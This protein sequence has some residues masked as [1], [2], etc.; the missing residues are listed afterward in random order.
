MFPAH[1]PLQTVVESDGTVAVELRLHDTLGKEPLDL[2]GRDFARQQ[3]RRGQFAGRARRHKV[4]RPLQE[5]RQLLGRAHLVVVAPELGHKVHFATLA[6]V[7]QVALQRQA[8]RA[9]LAEVAQ[10]RLHLVVG[11]A[12]LGDGGRLFS[13]LLSVQ[14]E[15]CI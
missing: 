9:V 8:H 4:V 11:D 1:I 12:Q 2:G 14:S 3:M 7:D 5:Q 15:M 10:P 6:A 13:V